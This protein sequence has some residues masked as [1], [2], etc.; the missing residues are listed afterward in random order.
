MSTDS[1]VR[2]ASAGSGRSPACIGNAEPV[3]SIVG[4]HHPTDF[5]LHPQ[6]QTTPPRP[7]QPE[8]M[9]LAHDVLDQTHG[10]CRD[11]NTLETAL[12]S[13][14]V[15]HPEAPV[16]AAGADGVVVAIPDR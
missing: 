6:A 9:D 13:L 8:A 1:Q 7:H 15:R 3:R 14:L 4:G 16:I 11:I 10:D 12:A 2:S 5:M